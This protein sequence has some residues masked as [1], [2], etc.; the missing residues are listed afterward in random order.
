MNVYAT[1]F[2]KNQLEFQN[3]DEFLYTYQ[4]QLLFKEENLMKS[5]VNNCEK[6]Q[7][8]ILIEPNNNSIV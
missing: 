8:T 2:L 1:F 7:N 4:F 3:T 5:L 6:S